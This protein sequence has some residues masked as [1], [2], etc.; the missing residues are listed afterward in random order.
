MKT[1]GCQ[2]LIAGGPLQEILI[3]DI[4]LPEKII[5]QF[6]KDILLGLNYLHDK[7]IVFADLCP[8]K[9]SKQ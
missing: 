2:V 4:F 3:Q 5:C 1:N 9:V 7:G 6:G 8:K